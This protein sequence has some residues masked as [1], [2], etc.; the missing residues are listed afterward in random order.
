MGFQENGSCTG[1][2]DVGVLRVQKVRENGSN[3]IV[4]K[5]PLV[6]VGEMFVH[7]RDG[8]GKESRHVY[9]NNDMLMG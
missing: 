4:C 3:G 1:V 7:G 6:E 2:G 8:W 5:V 9:Y